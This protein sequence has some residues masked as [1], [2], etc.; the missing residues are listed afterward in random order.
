MGRKRLIP[1]LLRPVARVAAVLVAV[2]VVAS[3]CSNISG[4]AP[5]ERADAAETSDASN[6]ADIRRNNEDVDAGDT[7]DA[8][9][10]L[11]AAPAGPH[12]IVLAHGFAGF[13]HLVDG[14]GLEYF[15]GVPAALEET[16]RTVWVTE[17]DPYNDSTTRGRQL[18]D[19][20]EARLEES[21]HEKVDIVAHS[22][23]GLDARW[24]AHHRPDLV[25]A[26]VTISS[27]HRGTRV[28]DVALDLVDYPAARSVLDAVAD[29]LGNSLYEEGGE[30]SE[31]VAAVRQMTSSRMEEF[32][33][34]IRDREGVY[35]A[36][37]A[38][39][40]D[41]HLGEEVCEPDDSPEFIEQ[42]RWDGD[43]V[44]PLLAPTEELLD[45][46]GSPVHANDGMVRVSSTKWGDFLGCIPADHLDEVGQLAGD[47]PG[48]G[49][50]WDHLDFY[51]NLEA[52]LRGVEH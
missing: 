45:G 37:I 30:A 7:G 8:G 33:E 29:L 48:G 4:V 42:W 22:Q 5:P 38:G 47:E 13:D 12:P 6:D 43:E 14:D 25:G 1:S 51:R 27:P 49:N 28:A 16:G 40:T 52:Y 17:V 2:G 21:P 23:G 15:F 36:S 39:R 20:I 10:E 41:G 9:E 32:N 11:D 26:V 24:V 35:Y 3:G 46:N 44:D 31:P 18:R 50:P 19:Q 34:E